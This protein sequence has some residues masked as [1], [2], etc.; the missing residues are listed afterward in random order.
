MIS[1]F[2]SHSHHDGALVELLIDLLRAALNLPS[3]EIRATSVDGF[4]LPGGS[5]TDEQLKREVQDATVLIGVISVAS[6]QS[7]YVM[8]ELGA[9]WGAEKPMIPLLVDVE[10]EV[11]GGPLKGLNTLSCRSSAQLHQLVEEI[12]GHLGMNLDRAAVYQKYVEKI[13]KSVGRSKR[14]ARLSPPTAEAPV[15]TASE[16]ALEA[17]E[18]AKFRRLEKI[19]DALPSTHLELLEELSRG[20]Q[21]LTAHSPIKDSLLNFKLI[22]FVG[23]VDSR[24]LLY[25]AVSDSSLVEYFR[26]RRIRQLPVAL[27]NV[28]PDERQF[29]SLFFLE[30]PWKVLRDPETDLLPNR[31]YSARHS[32]ERN[33][34]LKLS[35]ES[36]SIQTYELAKDFIPLLAEYFGVPVPRTEIELD[37]R[38]VA[39]R[40]SRGGGAA[41]S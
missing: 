11:L 15:R 40:N 28:S 26:R 8:F 24:Y 12:A 33:G 38:R 25:E 5:N 4:R 22:K 41:G 30:D 9:R 17:E 20:P 35:A 32:L 13:L 37:L 31:I 29:L 19:L 1:V 27:K 18:G 14:G 23:R 2:I 36:N 21:K 6:L 34:L 3:Q 7:A 10:A 16:A 39:A